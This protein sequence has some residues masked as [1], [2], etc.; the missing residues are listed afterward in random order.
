MKTL[1]DQ[2]RVSLVAGACLLALIVILKNVVGVPAEVLTRD[3]LLYIILYWALSLSPGQAPV[4]K[5]SSLDRP[6]YWVILLVLVTAA[7]VAVY[8]LRV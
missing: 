8:V 4:V 1:S 6:L 2:T 5:R 3:M 7:M